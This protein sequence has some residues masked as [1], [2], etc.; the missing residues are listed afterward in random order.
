MEETRAA[1]TPLY[2]TAKICLQ[3]QGLFTIRTVTAVIK[4]LLKLGKGK[5][6]NLQDIYPK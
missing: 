3:G 2:W 6:Y 4:K 5:N 1:M